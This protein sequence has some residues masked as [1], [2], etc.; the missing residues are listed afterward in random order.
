MKYEDVS[1]KGWVHV[2]T[3]GY[4][5]SI[6]PRYGDSLS[7]WEDGDRRH[8]NGRICGVIVRLF[9]S[10]KRLQSFPGILRKGG[11]LQIFTMTRQVARDT[12]AISG[13]NPRSAKLSWRLRFQLFVTACVNLFFGYGLFQWIWSPLLREYPVGFGVRFV[14]AMKYFQKERSPVTCKAPDVNWYWQTCIF[15]GYAASKHFFHK[16]L[17]TTGHFTTWAFDKFIY[18]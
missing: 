11:H 9:A 5:F 18:G 15:F 17:K 13:S 12:R 8:P 6:L 14:H 7:G 10:S 3:P 2:Q 1:S 16:D 4:L